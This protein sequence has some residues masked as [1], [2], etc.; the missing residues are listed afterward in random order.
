MP[1]TA[2]ESEAQNP[3]TSGLEDLIE[4]IKEL[5]LEV[6]V[7]TIER[8]Y[9]FCKEA[10]KD[11]KRCSGEPYFHHPIEV[12]KLLAELRLD[13]ASLVT[14]LLHD[15]V[16]DTLA[17]LDK[18]EEEFG[19][20]VAD[21]VDGVTKISKITF[22]TS[23]EKQA[24]NFR[25]MILAMGKDIRVILVKLC[26]RLHNMRTLQHLA[27]EKQM[28]IAK[29]T[30]DIYGPLANRLGLSSVKRE[31]EDLSLRYTKPEIY[32]KLVTS[33]AKKKEERETYTQEVKT[34]I[35]KCLSEHGHKNASVSGRPKHFYGIHLKMEKGNLSFEQVYDITGFRILV[36]TV[37]ACYGVLGLI[38]SMWTP[39]PGRF[40]DYIA[41]PKAN[42]YQS[43][44]TTIIGPGGEHLEV[45]IRTQKM[46]ETAE[47]G[48]AAHWAY[49]ENKTDDKDKKK[50]DW[51]NRLLES[52]RD[53]SD[54]SEF[55]ES[56]KLDLFMESVYVFTPNGE[57]KE[58]PQ[59]ATPLDFAFSVHTDVGNRCMGAKVNNRMVPLK[60]TLKS[61]DTVE[62]ITSSNQR[63]HKDWLKIVKTSRAKSKIRQFIKTLE[64]E[65][66]LEMGRVILERLLKRQNVRLKDVIKDSRL[67]K[68]AESFSHRSTDDLLSDMGYGKVSV[69]KVLARLFPKEH[70]NA[71][72]E[73][74]GALQRIFDKAA[75]D[76]QARN[77]VKVKGVDDLLVR[78]AKCCNVVP[79]D[80]VIGFITRGRGI[81]V[82]VRNCSK[83]FDSDPHRLVDIEWDVSQTQERSV[84]IKI[85]CVDQTGLL[86]AMSEVIRD[87]KANITQAQIGST[88]DLK[89]LC[90]FTITIKDLNHLNRIISKLEAIH[91]VISVHRVQKRES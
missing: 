57:V 28:K 89:S 73:K 51:L 35:E 5:A 1:V 43:L 56:V 68:V 78:F 38:H 87:Q 16:E 65:K 81:S 71:V 44:H 24:E 30:L 69:R 54:P 17:T 49:K 22:L 59:G 52:N 20:E 19:K 14:G 64:Y 10:H 15:T 55:L 18:I 46:H 36:E 79:G 13:T 7:D 25:K 70:E 86:A 76:S 2:P 6:D 90:N 66:S 75:K 26:D 91:G 45:Q 63:P 82:H 47:H 48:I 21:L 29:E 3:S 67:K 50:F 85:V 11:Q 8:A 41:I 58:F 74:K 33:V 53:L 72:K 83:I 84:K 34:I 39:L 23:E 80:E 4:F 9:R 40:K 12:C 32:Y 77:V 88:R 42:L 60:Y 61:G 31:L 27:P 62:I 37:E